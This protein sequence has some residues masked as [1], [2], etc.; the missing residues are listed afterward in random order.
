MIQVGSDSHDLKRNESPG[1]IKEQVLK[2]IKKS[3]DLAALCCVPLI[4][5][6]FHRICQIAR[7]LGISAEKTQHYTSLLFRSEIWKLDNHLVI[8][9]FDPLDLGDISVAEY[10]GMTI[11]II[12]RISHDKPSQFE[13]MTLATNREL[14]SDFNKKVIKALNELYE[15]SQC[16]EK[17]N[18]LFSW[19]HAGLI[20]YEKTTK[21]KIIEDDV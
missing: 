15:K 19:T 1:E 5:T 12:S 3:Y 7:K 9:N 18:C 13:T 20:E 6:N 4:E 2:E 14:I 8:P 11:H 17:R 16:L 21:E 10:L